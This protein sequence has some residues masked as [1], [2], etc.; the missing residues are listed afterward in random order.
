MSNF[1]PEIV[2][3]SLWISAREMCLVKFIESSN[4]DN[5]EWMYNV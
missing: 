1:Q 5:M 2:P 4:S 3:S